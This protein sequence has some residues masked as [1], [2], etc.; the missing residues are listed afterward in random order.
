MD[1]IYTEEKKV[2]SLS[3]GAFIAQVFGWM[4][5]GL[6]L[7]ASVAGLIIF[8][9]LRSD[10]FLMLVALL[11]LPAII[12]QL[13]L[14]VILSALGRKL[15]ALFASILFVV[16]SLFTGVTVGVIGINYQISSLFLA[17]LISSVMFLVLAIYGLLTKQDLSRWRAVGIFALFG[18]IL[19]SIINFILY[20]LNS[21]LF[22]TLNMIL[23]Y[24]IVVVFSIL[25]ASETNQLKKLAYEAEAS[26]KGYAR[27]AI[28]G[29]LDLYLDF[30]NLFL[31][32]LRITGRRN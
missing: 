15:N 5:V 25:I 19:V 24:V 23:N 13:L 6:L 4:T 32:V 27:Y 20:L 18:I 3:K 31:S 9:G 29:A 28:I 11:S 2:L 14:V 1:T 16:Y 17:F 21:S 30:I 12:I 10:S 7:T 22:N 26:G 8:L